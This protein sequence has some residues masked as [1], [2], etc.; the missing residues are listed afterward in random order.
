MMFNLF[1][2]GDTFFSLLSKIDFFFQNIQIVS[3]GNR[4]FGHHRITACGTHSA[5]V[6]NP[7]RRLQRVR[8]VKAADNSVP[9]NDTTRL[10]VAQ[11]SSM[12][13]PTHGPGFDP[14]RQRD[15]HRVRRRG[16]GQPKARGWR[17][18]GAGR[19]RSFFCIYTSGICVRAY[20]HSPWNAGSAF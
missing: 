13:L 14:H 1:K 11:W 10:P 9:K 19:N 20:L 18:G 2:L 5:H 16:S 6:P 12:P 4:S 7:P 3:F 8:A 15:E 17:P